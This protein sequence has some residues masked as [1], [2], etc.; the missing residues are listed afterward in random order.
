MAILCGGSEPPHTSRPSTS[1]LP[2]STAQSTTLLSLHPALPEATVNS[3]VNPSPKSVRQL[4]RIRVS[5]DVPH[6]LQLVRETRAP[7]P[8]QLPAVSLRNVGPANVLVLRWR[9]FLQLPVWA[10][11]LAVVDGGGDVCCHC[12]AMHSQKKRSLFQDPCPTYRPF[13]D[14]VESLDPGPYAM[15]FCM[16]DVNRP[17]ERRLPTHALPLWAWAATVS[18]RIPQPRH[19]HLHLLSSAYRRKTHTQ[20]ELRERKGWYHRGYSALS[21]H[22]QRVLLPD[23]L[24]WMGW[25]IDR[26]LK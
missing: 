19:V 7:C 21:F 12:L 14:L 24:T 8:C 17:T 9:T 6:F 16:P 5:R 23:Q 20:E 10:E 13:W 1:A 11:V 25:A 22:R 15:G 26:I 4:H 3:Q 2:R 18:T